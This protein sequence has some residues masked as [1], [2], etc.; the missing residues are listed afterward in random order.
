M[1]GSASN[2][3]FLAIALYVLA[4]YIFFFFCLAQRIGGR[5]KFL[6]IAVILHGLFVEAVSY[7]MPDIDSFWHAQGIFMFIGKRL[8]LYIICICKYIYM[9][10]VSF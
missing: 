6:W 1:Y 9:L 7:W 4:V 2:N 3:S 8:P 5:F 10:N